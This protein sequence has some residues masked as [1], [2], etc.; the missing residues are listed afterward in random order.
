MTALPKSE[1][2]T[3]HPTSAGPL[4]SLTYVSSAVVPFSR[5]ELLALLERCR[6]RNAREAITGLLLY[7]E[8]NF[9]QVLEGPEGAVRALHAKI[10]RDGRH[11]GMITV[12][13]T[14]LAKRQFDG[15]TMAFRDLDD[16]AVRMVPGYSEFLNAAL[17]GEEFA[18]QPSR[19]QKLL[20]AFKTRM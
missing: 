2:P 15:W 10:G 19:C 9:M 17:S 13:Q 16:P 20:L 3:D 12:L 4:F 6:E 18:G 11:R 7:K 8:G 1:P 5:A 14:P